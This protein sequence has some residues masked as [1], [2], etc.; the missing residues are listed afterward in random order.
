MAEIN[1]KQM[2]DA[3]LAHHE[4]TLKAAEDLAKDDLSLVAQQLDDVG[5]A[6]YEQALSDAQEKVEDVLHKLAGQLDD[7]HTEQLLRRWVSRYLLEPKRY[8]PFG[9]LSNTDE[10]T[11]HL[12]SQGKWAG[13]KDVRWL[14]R[15]V[16][17]D[18]TVVVVRERMNSDE[19][20]NAVR[21][22]WDMACR[23]LAAYK[24][25]YG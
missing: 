13:S 7:V 1:I 5:L 12:R 4:Q 18:G 15:Q 6:N 16:L 24:V 14:V 19:D 10:F 21:I 25:R 11:R 2:N 3:E 17:D 9:I 23:M 22:P 20:E 8:L